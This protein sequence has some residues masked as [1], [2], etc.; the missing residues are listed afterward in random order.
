MTELDEIP[1]KG[2]GR[3]MKYDFSALVSVGDR[4]EIVPEGKSFSVR[5]ARVI[6][7]AL[8]Q[9]K[10]KH[11]PYNMYVTRCVFEGKKISKII[12]IL[13]SDETDNSIYNTAY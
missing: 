4:L 7:S 11:K 6:T 5:K 3:P 9:Y 12:I 13:I 2:R 1:K 8:A 10:K